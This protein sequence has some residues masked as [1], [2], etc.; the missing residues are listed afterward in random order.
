MNLRPTIVGELRAILA[1]RFRSPKDGELRDDLDLGPSGFGLDSISLVEL[2][3]V[4]EERFGLAFPFTVFDGGP[5]TIGKLADHAC[6]ARD[7][8]SRRER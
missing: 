6:Q 8:S 1:S 4:C 2:L 7:Q 5:L 3:L